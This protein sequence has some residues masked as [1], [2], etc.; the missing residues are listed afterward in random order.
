MINFHHIDCL[1][2]MAD[3]P[4]KCYDLAIVDPPYCVGA[5][6]G[7]FGGKSKSPARVGGKINAKAYTNH[8][9]LP[10]KN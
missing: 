8:N 9:I 1:Q 4:D 3:K 5:A 10:D 7:R 6:D 2:F